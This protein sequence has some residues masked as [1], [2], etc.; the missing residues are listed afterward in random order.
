M[1]VWYLRL[2]ILNR[3][4]VVALKPVL[5]PLGHSRFGDKALS[6]SY[7]RFSNASV[8]NFNLIQRFEVL[9]EI[10]HYE[11]SHSSFFV[12]FA[13]LGA[14]M[15][16]TK[17]Y[18]IQRLIFYPRCYYNYNSVSRNVGSLHPT[19]ILLC[20]VWQAEAEPIRNL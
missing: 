19:G 1:R 8:T 17:S 10:K 6:A 4:S 14:R 2:Y 7:L 15:L 18:T 3:S 9:P 16:D 20:E 12:A 5:N 11:A 13:R